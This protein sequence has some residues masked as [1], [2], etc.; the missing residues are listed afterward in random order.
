MLVSLQQE[1]LMH[2]KELYFLAEKLAWLD[3]FTSHAIFAKEHQ[4]VKPE[5][6]EKSTIE[7][8]G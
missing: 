1:V 4:F 6:T 2:M 8:Q 5:I 3:L 7:I